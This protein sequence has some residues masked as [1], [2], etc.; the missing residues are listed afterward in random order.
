MTKVELKEANIKHLK[1]SL[2][3]LIICSS[4]GQKEGIDVIQMSL[5]DSVKKAMKECH[6]LL[7]TFAKAVES[8]PVVSSSNLRSSER[9]TKE[10]QQIRGFKNILKDV[11]QS[12]RS[13]AKPEHEGVVQAFCE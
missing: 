3:A 7:K 11:F 8:M 9:I 6:H 2:E 4:N 13:N 10:F 5:L 1:G 12:I